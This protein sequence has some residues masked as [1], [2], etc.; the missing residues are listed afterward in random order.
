MLTRKYPLYIPVLIFL[1]ILFITDTSWA[2][3]KKLTY[4]QVYQRGEPKLLGTLPRIVEW[5]DDDHYLELKSDKGKKEQKL[6]IVN[7][8]TGEASVYIDYQAL[9]IKLPKS[10]KMEKR[11]PGQK[12]SLAICLTMRMIFI[13]FL[14]KQ[15][16]LND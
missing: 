16:F 12:I 14:Q 1:A 4:Q 8:A 2:Q 5:L 7:A 10:F 3:N 15:E 13:I 6:M 9:D 11:Q